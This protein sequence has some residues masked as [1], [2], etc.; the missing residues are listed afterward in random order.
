MTK[1]P[2][3]LSKVAF[4]A[5]LGLA[6]LELSGALCRT[7]VDVADGGVD[8]GSGGPQALT[9]ESADECPDPNNYDCLGVC[10]QR[11]A[12]D[13][14][15]KLTEYCSGRG[16]CEPGC[17][18]SSTC[19]D[20]KVCVAGSCQDPGSAG[21]CGT[22]CDCLPGQICRDGVCQA[23]PDT[24]SS[25]DDCGRGQGDRCE[26]YQCNGFTGQCFDPDPQP[27]ADADDCT[28]RPGCEGGCLC[29]PAGQC[30][31]GGACTVDTEDADCG[32]G[33]Y[34]DDN[35]ECA[36]LPACAQDSDCQG[37]LTC[38]LGTQQCQRPR[39]CASPQDCTAAPATYCN[40]QLPTARC[41][42]PTCLNGGLTCNAQ[43]EQC[44]QDGR[45]VPQ[46][47]GSA[48][49]SD[50]Q[51]P[52]DVWPDTQY[53][54][55]ASGQGEC[56]PGCRS[57]ASCPQG[58][59]CNGARQCVTSG[60]GGGGGGGQYGATCTS[61]GDCQAGLICGLFSGTCTEQC[62]TACADCSGGACC[63][64]SGQP[65]CNSVGFCAAFPGLSC[66]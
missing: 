4:L 54:S 53:C 37:G 36:V 29:T 30:V 42:V 14:V 44:S 13:A 41:E 5:L 63:G 24:C 47:T 39:P 28:G 43:T 21:A 10:L 48:C 1:H 58:Q 50:A 20:G 15:C 17:R 55:F 31:P 65:F 40:T 27:C 9:C 34:C 51:C 26:A 16:Y 64:L 59:S 8:G 33:F 23:P 2:G 38:N 22:K 32:S 45:C 57:N 56:T 19:S 7:T 25:P 60:G 6:A 52:N 11:C 61:D 18:D 49:T 3:P 62:P 46:G 35:L 12:S 66:L